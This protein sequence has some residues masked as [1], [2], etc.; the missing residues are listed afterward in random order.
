[1]TSR[2]WTGWR[3]AMDRALYGEG[4]FYLAAGAPATAF[5]TAARAS[6]L[7][8]A[9]MLALASR[10]DAALGFP[11]EFSVV[12]VGAGGGELLAGLAGSAPARWSAWTSRRGRL[13][14]RIACSGSVSHPST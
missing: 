14:C 13:S 5:R 4:G 8:A 12:D 10:V 2:R 6:P 11:A 1:M 9:A 3:V 7:W